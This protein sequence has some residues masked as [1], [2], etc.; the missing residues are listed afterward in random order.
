MDLVDVDADVTW[1]LALT[2]FQLPYVNGFGLALV[3]V[4]PHFFISY[5]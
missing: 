3:F 2:L 1:S 4:V 5:L